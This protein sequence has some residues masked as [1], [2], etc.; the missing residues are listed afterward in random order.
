L[1]CNKKT[2]V[3][4]SA[5]E[6]FKNRCPAVRMDSYPLLGGLLN[7]SIYE[8]IKENVRLRGVDFEFAS[9]DVYL[10]FPSSWH[11][12]EMFGWMYR[13]HPVRHHTFVPNNDGIVFDMSVICFRAE[14][15]REIYSLRSWLGGI[16]IPLIWP[17]LLR[18]AMKIISEIRAGLTNPQSPEELVASWSGYL[19][20]DPKS[21]SFYKAP[22]E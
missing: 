6:H 15:E 17:D 21:L 16:F 11:I 20:E 12:A 7:E 18:E 2:T 8:G 19:C 10:A 9:R 1:D 22:G 13:Y 5:L 4:N 3:D 14:G